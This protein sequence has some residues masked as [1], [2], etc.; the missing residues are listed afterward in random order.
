[1]GQGNSISNS[2]FNYDE[3]NCNTYYIRAY[4]EDEET[5]RMTSCYWER[6]LGAT[7][8]Y[9]GVYA[10][11]GARR[12]YFDSKDFNDENATIEFGYGGDKVP[13]AKLVHDDT[14]GMYYYEILSSSALTQE[15]IITVTSG[16]KK[17]RMFWFDM[18]NNIATVTTLSNPNGT[19]AFISDLYKAGSKRIYFD[20]TMSKLSYEGDDSAVVKTGMGASEMYYIS[21]TSSSIVSSATTKKMTKAAPYSKGK[22]TWND[23]YYCDIPVGDTYICFVR[24]KFLI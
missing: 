7:D 5:E 22:N 19:A 18:N 21:G 4:G 24:L 14:T 13:E 16:G 11:T 8:L 10:G 6:R 17:Y 2:Y 15:D 9:S 1:M 20:A 23:V 12:L 3:N